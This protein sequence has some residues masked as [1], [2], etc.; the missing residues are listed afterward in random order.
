MS[1][2]LA[3]T[4]NS[5]Q[6]AANNTAGVDIKAGRELND[7]VLKEKYLQIC[8]TAADSLILMEWYFSAAWLF[9]RL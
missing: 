9:H 5:T 3:T 4:A 6:L 1:Q 7:S 8:D 2:S